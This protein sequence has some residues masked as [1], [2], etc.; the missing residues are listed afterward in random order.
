MYYYRVVAFNLVN[1]GTFSNHVSIRVYA[2]A[3]PPMWFKA[4]P[5]NGEVRLEWNPPESLGGSDLF[6]YRIYRRTS[7]GTYHI[8]DH[9]LPNVHSYVD[10]S[11][12][13]GVTYEYFLIAVTADAE[14][15][16]SEHQVVKPFGPPTAPLN[17][18]TMSGDRQVVLSWERPENNGSATII[19]YHVFAGRSEDNLVEIDSVKFTYQYIHVGLTN[20]ESWH[21]AVT[22]E[23]I[24]GTGERSGTV[25]G[26]AMGIPGVPGGMTATGGVGQVVLEWTE[27][28]ITGGTEVAHYHVQRGIDQEE[29]SLLATTTGDKLSY[30]DTEVENALVYYYAVSASNV[31]GESGRTDNVPGMSMGPPSAP[32][33]LDVLHGEWNIVLNW[34]PPI[35]DGGSQVTAYIVYRGMSALDMETIAQTPTEPVFI[36]DKAS[37]GRTYYY[38]VAAVN[39]AGEGGLS[40]V[41]DV[42]FVTKPTEPLDVMTEMSKD[43]ATITW[44]PPASDGGRPI[45][46]YV[47]LRGHSNGSLSRYKDLGLVTSYSDT[48]FDDGDEYW[49]AV[50]AANEKGLGRSSTQVKVIITSGTQ[51]GGDDGTS[52]W[53]VLIAAIVVGLVVITALVVM[54][55]RI[56]SQHDEG[57]SYRPTH[58]RQPRTRPH[59]AEDEDEGGEDDE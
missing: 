14:G 57:K 43:E 9:V 44:S 25:I 11:V 23:T 20:G 42:L 28:P 10:E 19:R 33:N 53:V 5:G 3:S 15:E 6:T 56:F 37:P 17:L 32:V 59:E 4:S 47:L 36:D 24:H 50:K 54:R 45:T 26:T 7:N 34:N 22:A 41:I 13:N 40:S 55:Y 58:G 27:P 30:T 51:P 29:M 35:K 21:Y 49:Y 12:D 38:A 46:G 39:D 48:S 52:L 16:E 2:P 1:D 18:T 8:V 31:V